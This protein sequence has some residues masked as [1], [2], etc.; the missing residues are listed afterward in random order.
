MKGVG[1]GP[2]PFKDDFAVY[3]H[4][5]IDKRSVI[6]CFIC[7][8]KWRV[9]DTAEILTR[10]GHKIVNHT[11]VGWREATQML[12]RSTNTPSSSEIPLLVQNPNNRPATPT[13]IDGLAVPDIEL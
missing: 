6:R 13:S 4:T 12:S 2:A 10:N 5:Y 11:K 9:E 7:G 3:L 1:K 8:M